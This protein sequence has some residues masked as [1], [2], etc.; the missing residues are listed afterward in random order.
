M[1]FKKLTSTIE[2][3]PAL[4][5]SK[6]QLQVLENMDVWLSFKKITTTKAYN[7]ECNGRPALREISKEWWE[8]GEQQQKIEVGDC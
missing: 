8:N 1:Y 3:L 4:V 7:R 2:Q 5:I 6:I